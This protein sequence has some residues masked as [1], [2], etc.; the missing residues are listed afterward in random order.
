MSD[1]TPPTPTED[2]QTSLEPQ[3]RQ[4]KNKKTGALR[5]IIETAILAILIFVTV[6]AVVLNFRVEGSSM[7]PT[8]ENG[9]MILVNRNAYREFN[10]GDLVDW[11]PG[12]PEQEWFTI[13]D[14][15]EPSRGD[16]IV[17]TPPEPGDQKPYIKRVIGL[18]GDHVQITEDLNVLINGTAIDEPYIGD[19]RNECVRVTNFPHC[20]LTVPEG[21][22]FVMG[23]HRNNSQ[24]SR[25]FSVV[26]ED[27][28]IGKAWL[29]Y[30]PIG[31]FGTVDHPD[32]PELNPGD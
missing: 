14:W 30:W 8:L 24:D 1:P 16:V 23:D 28:M 13:V 18:P 4:T 10:L 25:Y 26:E 2:D 9:E 22:Y 5:E 20:D 12:V 17:F 6:R 19:Y 11:I 3:D 15:G 31:N 27:R 32:Y 21:H 7:L 29:V